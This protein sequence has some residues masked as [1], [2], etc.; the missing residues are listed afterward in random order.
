MNALYRDHD[1]KSYLVVKQCQW[2]QQAKFVVDPTYTPNFKTCFEHF[3]LHSGGRG[4][5]DAIQKGLNL[6][7]VDMAP[8]R[9][10][11]ARFGNTSAAST[12]YMD[13]TCQCYS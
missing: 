6:G 10:A 5:L 3:L 8:S 9:A 12:W 11:L 1:T 13:A 4:V 2:T 7:E